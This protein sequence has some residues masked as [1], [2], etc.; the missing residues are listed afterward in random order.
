MLSDPGD[1]NNTVF[2][3]MADVSTEF[4]D[5]LARPWEKPQH[6][7]T[8]EIVCSEVE[9]LPV[10]SFRPRLLENLLVEG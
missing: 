1:D 6:P 7:T 8:L 10:I 4:L 2:V 3:Y 9:F 5:K